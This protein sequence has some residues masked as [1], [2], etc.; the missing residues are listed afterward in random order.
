MNNVVKTAGIIT[1]GIIVGAFVR[2]VVQSG[3]ILKKQ[4]ILENPIR[5]VKNL[6]EKEE[7]PED[8]NEFFI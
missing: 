4:P 3:F 1:S 2:K 7:K 8:V 6:F 5:S